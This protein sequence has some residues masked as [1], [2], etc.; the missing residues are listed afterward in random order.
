MSELYILLITY[1]FI[2]YWVSVIAFGL[3]GWDK[4]NAV[5]GKWRIPEAVLLCAAIFG[6]GWGA[7]MGMLLFRHKTK[8]LLFTICNPICF[9]LQLALGCYLFYKYNAMLPAVF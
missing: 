1:I 8:H 3:Y 5:Y 2:I 6:G 4:H 9:V 7:L